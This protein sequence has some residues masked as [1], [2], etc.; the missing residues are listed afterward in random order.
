MLKNKNSH[1][2]PAPIEDQIAK[3]NK[4]LLKSIIVTGL[5]AAALT[6]GAIAVGKSPQANPN[7]VKHTQTAEIIN[8]Q[9]LPETVTVTT[10]TPE[11]GK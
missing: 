11:N 9:G 6:G 7:M 4:N 2:Q 8:Q 1:R 3:S 5:G 10:Q